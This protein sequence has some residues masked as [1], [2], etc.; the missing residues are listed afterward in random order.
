MSGAV[1]ERDWC[2]ERK[3]RWHQAS[4]RAHIKARPVPASSSEQGWS[5]EKDSGKSSNDEMGSLSV[6]SPVWTELSTVTWFALMCFPPWTE[7]KQSRPFVLVPLCFPTRSSKSLLLWLRLCQRRTDIGWIALMSCVW[8]DITGGHLRSTSSHWCQLR[9]QSQ[10]YWNVQTKREVIMFHHKSFN[11][12]AWRGRKQK[13]R[14]H[15]E[16]ADTTAN[17]RQRPQE[18][19]RRRTTPN[20]NLPPSLT[21]CVQDKLC[22]HTYLNEHCLKAT[23]VSSLMKHHGKRVAQGRKLNVF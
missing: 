12:F 5:M 16:R 13:R 10:S 21:L 22:C 8:S 17:T 7:K 11:R 3:V 18:T 2:F 4:S 23:C 19:L 20:I 15:N 6:I 1:P 9:G 14:R